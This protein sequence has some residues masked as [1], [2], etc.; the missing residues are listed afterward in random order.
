M[1]KKKIPVINEHH[2]VAMVDALKCVDIVF[3]MDGLDDFKKFAEVSDLIFKNS[4]EV[5]GNEV[6]FK[7]KVM[8]IP[9]I[10]ELSS[11]TEIIQDIRK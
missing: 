6:V 7:D 9:D 10:K 5:Y 8:V 1:N 3:R 2:R 4:L 11:T